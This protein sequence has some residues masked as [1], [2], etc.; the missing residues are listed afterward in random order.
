MKQRLLKLLLVLMLG[1]YM[2]VSMASGAGTEQLLKKAEELM[3]SHRDSEALA[4]YE[5]VLLAAPENYTALCKAS[6]LICRMG[7]RISDDG[8]KEAFYAKAKEYA[9][10]AYAIKPADAESNF[11]MALS[12][13]AIAMVSGP[14][15]RLAGINQMKAFLDAALA[16][17]KKH[18]GSWYLLGR[19]HF[20]MANLN[21]AEITA[22]KMFFGGVSD[23]ATNEAAAE[24][25]T[26]AIKYNPHQIRYYYDL[27]T[28]YKEMKNAD[29]CKQTLEQAIAL[30]VTT[31]EELE[32]SRRCKLLLQDHKK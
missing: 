12:V 9:M 28:V 20:K 27:A 22:A 14:K 30:Q 18:A 3:I 31:R 25:I 2:P 1:F 8:T 21:F 6:L 13:G 15:Q 17:D 32:I 29:A 16:E 24:A 4:M 19:W 7:E 10:R 23:I 5:Q 26:T 11:V